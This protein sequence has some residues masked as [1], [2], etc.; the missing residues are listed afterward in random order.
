MDERISSVLDELDE[1]ETSDLLSGEMEFPIDEFTR[2]RIASSVKKRTSGERKA[3]RNFKGIGGVAASFMVMAFLALFSF[4]EKDLVDTMR[5]VM[6]YIPGYGVT[7]SVEGL[8]EDI[9][10]QV[11]D[12]VENLRTGHSLTKEKY[13]IGEK[14]Y[15]VN[16]I[17]EIDLSRNYESMNQIMEEK[18]E[19]L[20]IV[21][22]KGESHYSIL[23]GKDRGRYTVLMS[24][25]AAEMFYHSLSLADPD[26]SGEIDLLFYGGDQYLINE[27]AMVYQI[28]ATRMDYERNPDIFDRPL[29]EKIC[30][31]L[32]Q[33]NYEE[34]L[35]SKPPYQFGSIGLMEQHHEMNVN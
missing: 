7:S 9:P 28:P 35:K 6:E 8:G 4:G 5:K 10:K 21:E 2:R 31:E 26:R 12:L 20:F 15:K 18:E 14:G 29:D 1:K 3:L 34:S 17:G 22:D 19:W 23:I 30:L 13:S 32:I 24:G 11:L 33:L 25:G 27:R 16:Y